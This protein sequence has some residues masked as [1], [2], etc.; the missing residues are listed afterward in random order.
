[1]A[2]AKP[3]T[4]VIKHGMYQQTWSLLLRLGLSIGLVGLLTPV[5]SAAKQPP[6]QNQLLNHASPYLALHGHDPVAWQT[7]SKSILER[8]AK[9]KKLIFLSLGYFSCHWC[10]VMQ[11]ESFSNEAVAAKL[12]KHFIPVKVDRELFPALD[13]YMIDFVQRTR[14]HAGWPLNVFV[15]PD[16]YPV[17]GMVYLPKS[18]FSAL[19]DQINQLWKKNPEFMRDMAKQAAAI[20]EGQSPQLN[21]S[22]SKKD[23]EQISRV[24][25]QQAMS[26]AD[27]MLGGFGSQSKFPMSAQLM[28]M[29]ELHQA[30]DSSFV[31]TCIPYERDFVAS[32]NVNHY[33][34]QDYFSFRQFPDEIGETHKPCSFYHA[35]IKY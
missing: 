33:L 11:R 2:K 5:I 29:L 30:L 6:L 18:Q 20:Q 17:V 16:G 12:N 31:E 28:A 8:A 32:S 27:E 35:L 24:F 25:V 15:S 21:A 22:L 19:L 1:M 23:A 3:R 14:G 4:K 10:H 34:F 9:E 26:Q 7:W 13:A